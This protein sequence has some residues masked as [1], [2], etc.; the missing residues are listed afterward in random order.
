MSISKF[1]KILRNPLKDNRLSIKKG[2]TG[3]LIRTYDGKFR[4]VVFTGNDGF[5]GKGAQGKCF[6]GILKNE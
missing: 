3:K 2:A 5:L 6:L 4:I 1:R